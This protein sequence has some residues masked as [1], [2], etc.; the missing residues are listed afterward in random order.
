MS[1]TAVSTG[2]NSGVL[3]GALEQRKA[4]PVSHKRYEQAGQG[5]RREVDPDLVQVVA[6]GSVL[7]PRAGGPGVKPAQKRLHEDS[8]YHDGQQGRNQHRRGDG[9]P[10]VGQ[11]GQV[12]HHPDSGGHEQQG[13]VPEQTACRV[14]HGVRKVSLES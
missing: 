8:R 1:S 12:D 10:F 11:P 4:D 14:S 2:F 3:P 5:L 7:R 13:K 6:H 9:H